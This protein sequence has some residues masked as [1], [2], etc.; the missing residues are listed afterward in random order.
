AFPDHHQYQPD[1]LHFA[2]ANL[3]AIIIM[4]EKDAVK[5]QSFADE[6]MWVYAVD[7]QLPDTFIANILTQL[8]C[9]HG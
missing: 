7:A 4:T 1:D 8:G 5:C 9:N 3:S 6:R 2:D